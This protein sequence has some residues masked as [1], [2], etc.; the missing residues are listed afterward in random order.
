MLRLPE[1]GGHPARRATAQFDGEEQAAAQAAA[2]SL[3]NAG[4]YGRALHRALELWAKDRSSGVP[5]RKPSEHLA[6]ALQALGLQ[7]KREQREQALAALERIESQLGRWRPL[8]V[9]APFTLDF[10]EEGRPLL[11]SGYIDLVA[12]DENGVTCL[13]DYKTGDIKADHALQLALYRQAAREVYGLDVVRCLIGRIDQDAFALVAIDPAG[14]AELR[15]RIRAVRDGLERCDDTAQP[16]EWCW[17]CG[18]RG[19]P[20]RD[21][22]RNKTRA[23]ATTI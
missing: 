23:K 20:C 4:D 13:L 10:G 9:E 16:G 7:P 18:Y 5:G 8:F 14:D 17:S 21:Y 6:G 12:L 3:L 1:I 11:V 15:Q 19:A 22:P 2:D